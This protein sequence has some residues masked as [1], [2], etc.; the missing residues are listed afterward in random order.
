MLNGLLSGFLP[1]LWVMCVSPCS[2]TNPNV[3]PVAETAVTAVTSSSYSVACYLGRLSHTHTA[4]THCSCS[5]Y[6]T[7]QIKYWMCCKSWCSQYDRKANGMCIQAC[8]LTGAN[9]WLLLWVFHTGICDRVP[10][11][12]LHRV[13]LH[14]PAYMYISYPAQDVTQCSSHRLT[15]CRMWQVFRACFI[16]YFKL[17]DS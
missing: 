15:I 3:N 6:Y 10:L 14:A 7:R 9:W 17:G 4:C 13:A 1:V 8:M 11:T 2:D 5:I 16:G 12:L